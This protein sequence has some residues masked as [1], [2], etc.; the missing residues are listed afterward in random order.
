M[1]QE[2]ALR[3][4]FLDGDGLLKAGAGEA[5][6]RHIERFLELCLVCCHLT[7]GQPVHNCRVR[8][9][10]SGLFGPIGT[11]VIRWKLREGGSPD[12]PARSF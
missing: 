7:G 9:V 5:Y 10:Q 2:Q 1:Y 3:E 12:L 11:P 4:Q 8:A 6:Q